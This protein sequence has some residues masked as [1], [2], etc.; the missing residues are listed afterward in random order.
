MK[1]GV[2]LFGVGLP[3][4]DSYQLV[5][6]TWTSSMSLVGKFYPT[7]GLFLLCKN[8][9]NL[10]AASDMPVTYKPGWLIQGKRSGVDTEVSNAQIKGFMVPYEVHS[11]LGTA[12]PE[13]S[14]TKNTG[15]QCL[16]GAPT[17]YTNVCA[18][19]ASSGTPSPLSGLKFHH[20]TQG[21]PL[22]IDDAAVGKHWTD[23][24]GDGHLRLHWEYEIYPYRRNLD[25]TVTGYVKHYPKT[26]DGGAPNLT[27]GSYV[28]TITYL[29]TM[30]EYVTENNNT[31]GLKLTAFTYCTYLSALSSDLILD[32]LVGEEESLNGDFLDL[33]YNASN[34]NS[35]WL[36]C[37]RAVDS[38]Q[39]FSGSTL[40]IFRDTYHIKKLLPELRL[41]ANWA[42]PKSWAEVFLWF[43]YGIMP[44]YR[45]AIDIVKA[46]LSCEKENWL[47][48]A[49]RFEKS[50]T[51]YATTYPEGETH[52]GYSVTHMVSAR[53]T[54]RPKLQIENLFEALYQ[55]LSSL[56]I[57]ISARNCWELVPFSFVLDWFINTGTLMRFADWQ[58]QTCQY[59]L[60][61]L[62]ISH[63]REMDKVPS[64]RYF[65]GSSGLIKLVTYNR[66]LHK[67][68]PP[69]NFS[70]EILDPSTHWM[71]GLA[72]AIAM[73]K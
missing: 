30:R 3:D 50:S 33:S 66:T 5:V 55:F 58:V 49:L 56:N 34:G 69:S 46:F 35:E 52:D 65:S 17:G 18:L 59:E 51:K 25:I 60:K 36:T 39:I 70:G 72:L 68:F 44:T 10:Y 62:I 32:A 42:S 15:W 14:G 37:Q 63:K 1:R 8:T 4:T 2:S 40:E 6:M 7:V 29:P 48:V 67:V 43:K 73:K 57:G 47:D 53:V 54:A 19:Y 45:D 26:G 16:N 22:Y 13:I 64:S 20:D 27:E 71:E 21:D 38:F 31:S 12:M 9:G 23:T 41:F 11:V 61:Q 24:D 28:S